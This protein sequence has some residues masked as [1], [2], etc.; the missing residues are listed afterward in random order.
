M[1]FSRSS[2]RR[3]AKI[4]FTKA[5]LPHPGEP[6]MYK[7]GWV[8]FEPGLELVN[9]VIK[10][11]MR[12]RSGRRPAISAELLQVA[13]RSAREHVCKGTVADGVRGGVCNPKFA[14]AMNVVG[15]SCEPRLGV[16]ALRRKAIERPGL[17]DVQKRTEWNDILVRECVGVTD[18]VYDRLRPRGD[19]LG[20]ST[21]NGGMFSLFPLRSVSTKDVRGRLAHGPESMV[22]ASSSSSRRSTETDLMLAEEGEASNCD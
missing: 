2:T 10:F 13:R 5:V 20:M 14:I 16:D 3:V 21:R 12:R 6:E 11:V 1:L 17:N 15:V 9:A 8:V 7:T 4:E 22:D 19:S 18:S